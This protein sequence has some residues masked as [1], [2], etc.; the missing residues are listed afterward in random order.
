[1]DDPVFLQWDLTLDELCGSVKLNLQ[2]IIPFS[3]VIKRR[4][5]YIDSAPFR[6]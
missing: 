6:L 5:G 2:F 3:R 4:Y 1:M